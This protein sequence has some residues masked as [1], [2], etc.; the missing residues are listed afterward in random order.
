MDTKLFCSLLYLFIVSRWKN[1][2]WVLCIVRNLEEWRRMKKDINH[3][4]HLI[5][6]KYL[7]PAVYSIFSRPFVR[8]E[9][10]WG[11]ILCSWLDIL[12]LISV[13]HFFF[14]EKRSFI[15]IIIYNTYILKDSNKKTPNSF[16]HH[17][18][19]EEVK[20]LSLS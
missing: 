7:T 16:T 8:I 18:L 2:L 10:T 9:F 5:V 19:A 11:I 17:H 6:Y 15:M 20:T 12:N 14:L 4:K 1:S 13:Q 3:C